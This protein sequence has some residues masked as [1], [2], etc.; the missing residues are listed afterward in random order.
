MPVSWDGSESIIDINTKIVKSNLCKSILLS[1]G[2][3][4]ISEEKSIMLSI[5][6][7]SMGEI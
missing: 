5:S 4:Y 1:W 7:L 6:C 3:N 2:E